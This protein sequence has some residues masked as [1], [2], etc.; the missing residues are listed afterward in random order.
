MPFL[1]GMLTSKRIR[2]GRNG[3]ASRWSPRH[4]SFGRGFPG[5]L[6][7]GNPRHAPTDEMA[8]VGNRNPHR[9]DAA[10]RLGARPSIQL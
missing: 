3:R 2:S 4:L 5:G 7:C 6:R 9:S 1:P 10:P 8:I